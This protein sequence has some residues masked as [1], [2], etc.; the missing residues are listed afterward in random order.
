MI[1]SNAS[2][3]LYSRQSTLLQQETFTKALQRSPSERMAAFRDA[4]E[5]KEII[6]RQPWEQAHEMVALRRT[7]WSAL[8]KWHLFF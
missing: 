7:A 4:T 8:N 1:E 2:L 6:W 3:F 5:D